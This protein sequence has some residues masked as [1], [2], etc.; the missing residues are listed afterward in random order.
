MKR[1]YTIADI[2][3]Y[4]PQK[5]D[6]SGALLDSIGEPERTGSWLIYGGSGCGKTTFAFQIAKELART[7]KVAY[8][9]LEE[10]L[11]LS[12]RDHIVRAGMHDV[13]SNFILLDKESINDLKLRLNRQRSPDVVIIDS[14]RYTRC[15]YA[16]YISL[17][18]KYRR[19][20]FI[21]I[22]HGEGAEP[23]YQTSKAIK[24]NSNVKIYVNNFMAIVTSRYGGGKP[25]VISRE[26]AVECG[27]LVEY[28]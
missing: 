9:S 20:L 25:Y 13:K 8:D 3:G 16:E 7:L 12:V 26:K 27:S 18:E 19:K 15:D 11:S 10:G 21:I 6:I 14:W 28:K 23:K 17:I 2:E 24:F 22:D 5:I 4:R 1:A